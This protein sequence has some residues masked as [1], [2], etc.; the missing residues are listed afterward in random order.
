MEQC[1]AACS[2]H[3][4]EVARSRAVEIFEPVLIE[5]RG[6]RAIGRRRA[7]PQTPHRKAY[8]RGRP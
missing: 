6:K 5:K 1:P 3:C 7:D 8:R 2:D 4:G